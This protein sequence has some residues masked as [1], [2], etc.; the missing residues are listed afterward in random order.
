VLAIVS[1]HGGTSSYR[2]RQLRELLRSVDELAA[3]PDLSIA[4]HGV[5]GAK[6]VLS[7][8][9]RGFIIHAYFSGHAIQ[10][11]VYGP[12]APGT[13]QSPRPPWEYRGLTGS[14]STACLKEVI[15]ILD[16]GGSPLEHIRLNASESRP[17]ELDA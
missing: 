1:F 9:D 16:R 7:I 4:E 3:M 5:E 17:V 14:M 6:G 10:F 15:C 2:K 8:V 12:F 13:E 11:E